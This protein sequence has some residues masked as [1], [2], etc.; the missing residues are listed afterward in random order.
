MGP[1]PDGFVSV[2]PA[3]LIQ[4]AAKEVATPWRTVY[5]SF[6]SR[7]FRLPAW[8][9]GE[10]PAPIRNLLA[11]VPAWRT[12]DMAAQE[13]AKTVEIP[14]IPDHQM[15]CRIGEGAYGEVWLARNVLGTYR[16]VKVV[17]R[18]TFDDDRPFDREFEGIQRFEPISRSHPGFVSILHVG[19]NEATRWFYYVM[20]VADDVTQEQS[21][22]PK[23]Y[24]PRTL[25]AEIKKRGRL[26]VA[27]CVQIGISLSAALAH[28]HRQ[29]LIHRDIKPSNIIYIRSTPRLADV[30]LVTVAGEQGSCVGTLGF[31]PS[32]DPGT[33]QADIFALGKVLYQ[34]AVGQSA[35]E[36]PDLPASVFDNSDKLQFTRFNRVILKACAANPRERYQTAEELQSALAALREPESK[37]STVSGTTARPAIGVIARP[38]QIT[39]LYKTGAEP[40]GRLLHL[41]QKRLVAQGIDVCFDERLTV[42]VPWA[43]EI[44]NKICAADAVVILLSPASVQS[45]MLAYEIEMA[46]HAAQQHHGRPLCLPVRVQFNGAWPDPLRTF[47]DP[48]QSF[49]WNGPDDDDRL[50]SELVGAMETTRP[51]P[52]AVGRL[53]IEP[54]GGAVD[55]ASEF[56]IVRPTD[57]VFRQAVTRWD[58]IILVKGARQM[59][60]TSL[61]ARGLRQARDAGARVALSDFQK[62]SVQ[63][64]ESAESFFLALGGFLADQLS[65]DTLP[66][67]TWD[68]RRSPN[69]NFERFLRRE[70]LGKISGQ[71]V[72]GLDE[73]DRLFSCS[74]GSE[75]FGLFRSWHNERALDPTGPW[76]RLTLAIAYAT[77]AHLFI[78]DVNQSPFNVGTRLELEDFTLHQVADLNER[79]GSPLRNEGELKQ[80]HQLLGGQPY[81]VRRALNELTSGN[82]DF[83]TLF[84]EADRDEGIFG[85]HLRRM[86]VMLAK[87]AELTEVV[88]GILQGR[89]RPDV[90]SFYR[91]RSGGVMRGESLHE[92]RPRC[93]I[94][95]SYLKRHLQ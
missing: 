88:R 56:Y 26:P 7:V 41:L 66:D 19:R 33:P 22:D 27:E 94:Y 28:L 74:F 92:A 61:L 50:V 83:E 80:F 58:S 95:G 44:E 35:K 65:L 71:L 5:K 3:A 2:L 73:V 86:L 85:D 20:E 9:L 45:E 37:A 68:K 14:C 15:V 84:A 82:V 4:S 32:E 60:K 89:P 62:L 48:R 63:N 51:Q 43:R 47:L 87:D 11:R 53:R 59:G 30:G 18:T 31:I 21:I 38:R 16:G 57:E 1:K 34:I 40:D 75:V 90:S 54:A 78:T 46:H 25:S 23:T 29:G 93:E 77:E 64:L 8:L 67:A 79:Y 6:R 81:L 70:V 12:Q 55:L 10:W 69:I 39:L 17:R 52:S 24:V 91:L 42:G 76:S 13:N 49:S 36:F 72:W